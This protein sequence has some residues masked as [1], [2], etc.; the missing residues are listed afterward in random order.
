MGIGVFVSGDLISLSQAA[1]E[2]AVKRQTLRQ[3]LIDAGYRLPQ[4]ERGS[5]FLI[6]EAVVR[7]VIEARLVAKIPEEG[8]AMK[9]WRQGDVLFKEVSGFPHSKRTRRATG[10]ILE[11]EAT[12]HIHRLEDLA[13][14]EVLEIGDGLFV[15]VSAEGGVSIIHEEHHPIVL[16]AGRYEVVRQREYAPD[17]IRNVID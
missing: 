14:A 15:N 4:V 5:K 10:H 9:T 3:W 11:G 16:P 8:N 2:L 7:R 1:R 12:G 6:D 17:E 13:A